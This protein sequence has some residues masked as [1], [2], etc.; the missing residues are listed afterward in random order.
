MLEHETVVG[1]VAAA[2]LSFCRETQRAPELSAEARS[3]MA[4]LC[5]DGTGTGAPAVLA[6]SATTSG[7]ASSASIGAA[8]ASE[9]V[10]FAVQSEIGRGG[11][12]VVLRARQ[13]TLGR[14][15]ALKV[16]NGRAG[17]LDDFVAEARVTGFLDHANIVPVHALG[18]DAA[19]RLQL[20]MKLV[21]GESWED[22]LR[23][24]GAGRD[25]DRHIEIFLAVC[26][27][28]S[29]AHH[30]GVIHRDLKPDNVMVGEFGQVFVMDWGLAVAVRGDT[31]A[32]LGV[33]HARD[34]AVPAGTPGYMAPEL[35][36]GDGARQDERTD[37]Y[38][39]GA[40]LHRVVAGA[41][42]HGGGT[43]TAILQS[44]QISRPYRYADDVP[45]E[46]A[47]I[48]NRATHADPGERFP[49][50]EALR[51]AVA[52]FVRHRQASELAAKGARLVTELASAAAAFA[53]LGAAERAPENARIHGLFASARFALE[54][55]LGVWAEEPEALA[56]LD[57]LVRVMVEH[58]LATDDV[59]T[60]LSLLP[61]CDESAQARIRAL[62]ADL[63]RRAAELEHLRDEARLNDWA[64]MTRAIG[65]AFVWGSLLAATGPLL[66]HYAVRQPEPYWNWIVIA[67]WAVLLPALG[68]LARSLFRGTP[69]PDSRIAR[70]LIGTWGAIALGCMLNQ[71]V[72]SLQGLR[73]ES[74]AAGSALLIGAGFAA[75]AFQTRWWVLAPAALFALSSLP[76]A[77]DVEDGLLLFVAVWLVAFVGTGVA[78]LRG[79]RLDPGADGA[80]AP[81]E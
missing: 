47:D 61:R 54:E 52:A 48:C 43:L 23:R 30:R 59:A 53:D 38:L 25:V 62:Q 17:T 77:A 36:V 12:G 4:T 18:R 57:R 60:A 81:L 10:E 22:L 19:G 55:A 78:L 41:A 68:L 13:R 31:A 42:R 79:A 24:E 56:S 20:A 65:R 34:V 58:A 46:L 27:A 21:T 39:L 51:D 45:R 80:T 76:I 6:A 9:A 37:V 66:A 26:N 67:A 74:N 44:A 40:C 5:A 8:A 32:R 73:L 75:M 15:V 28:V 29:F 3:E 71:G 33:R 35:A 72:V 50:V 64:P 1:S 11:M 63:A 2:Q 7:P 14:D 70:R 69:I 49:S 16:P